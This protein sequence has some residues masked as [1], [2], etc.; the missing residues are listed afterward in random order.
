M[1]EVR[2]GS[3][4]PK[5]TS[6]YYV[7]TFSDF[8]D[9]LPTLYCIDTLIMAIPVVEFSMEGYKITKFLVKNQLYSNEITKI[10]ELE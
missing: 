7:G 4:T 6:M 2:T 1:S 8:F 5:R 10:W 9:T 3:G